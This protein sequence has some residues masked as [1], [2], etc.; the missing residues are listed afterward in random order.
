MLLYT[1]ALQITAH[2]QQMEEKRLFFLHKEKGFS[3]FCLLGL[4][5]S[6]FSFIRCFA[7]N[8]SS[9]LIIPRGAIKEQKVTSFVTREFPHN[10]K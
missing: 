5:K 1:I 4:H 7:L 3:A 9:T 2:L 8:F 10:A 6:L